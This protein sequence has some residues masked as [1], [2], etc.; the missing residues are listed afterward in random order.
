MGFE[1]L[2]EFSE[3]TATKFFVELGDLTGEAGIT[4]AKNGGSV[5][6]G[7]GDAVRRLVE[8][9]GAVFD[10]E[11]FEGALAFA[12]TSG[13]EAEKDELVVRKAGGGEG[14]EERCRTGNGDDRDAMANG[15]SDQAMAGIGDEG[16]ASITD[17]CDGGTSFHGE[18]EF[19]SAGEFVVLV[20]ADER[21]M[22]LEM[23]QEFEGVAG[24]FAGDLLDFFEN[25]QGAEGDVFEVADGSGD[26]IEAATRRVGGSI[27]MFG[28]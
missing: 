20:V 23:I 10:A 17:Q 11:A 4:I 24:V 9:E 21:L 13:K 26:Q 27:G 8:D 2:K 19:G 6:D 22:D 28:G 15:E 3:L 7:V 14:G 25:A 1:R 5:G 16:H 18:H 12:G